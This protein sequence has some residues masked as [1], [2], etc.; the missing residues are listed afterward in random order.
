MASVEAAGYH[1]IGD[2]VTGYEH[3][4]SWEYIGDESTLDPERIE[5]IVFEVHPDGS[6]TIASAMYIMPQ[7]STMD[8]VPDLAG[9]LTT[10]HDHQ[11]LCW[12]AEGQVVGLLVN[13]QCRPAGVFRPTPP[14]LHVWMVENP[15]GPFAGLEGHGGS[16]DGEP[17]AHTH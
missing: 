17:C 12:N 7:G 2:R 1:S 15:C 9:E 4:I 13:G 3:F 11:N 8:D 5:S 16:D 6:E 14:M 10:W